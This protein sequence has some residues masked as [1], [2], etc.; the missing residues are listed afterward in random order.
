MMRRYF[1]GPGIGL[2]SCIA[3]LFD[4]HSPCRAAIT[5]NIYNLGTLGG[6]ESRGF[7]INN[8][9]QA[10]GYARTTN[11]PLNAFR[12]SGLPGAGGSMADLGTLGGN[13]AVGNAINASGQV[14]GYSLLSGNTIRHA[15][16]YSGTPG[17]GGMMKDLGTLGGPRSEAYGINDSGQIAGLS[18]LNSSIEHAFRYSGTPGAG[19]VMVDLGTLGGPSSEGHAINNLGQVAGGSYTTAGPY[20]AF[21]YTGT[22]GAGG[23]MEDLGALGGAGSE[24]FGINDIGQVTGYYAPVP[25]SFHAFRYTGT[26]GAGGAM[27]DLTID[28]RNSIGRA[29]NDGGFVVG[30]LAVAA[31]SADFLPVLWLT[32]PAN[33]PVDLDK[34]LD[35][36]NPTQGAYW[37]LVAVNDINNNG[38]ITGS[39]FYDDGPGGLSDGER[40]YILDASGAIPEPAGATLVALVAAG[41]LGPLA[42]GGRA[43]GRANCVSEYKFGA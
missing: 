7:A 30:D 43:G 1:A 37:K 6:D 4:L 32:D 39:G 2:L 11:G 31:G 19:G 28:G 35:A 21:R 24:A 22:P 38:L 3:F 27:V 16:L 33:T 9:G 42:R 41:A 17:A 25:D 5:A 29:I 18:Y 13:S 14:A 40:A 34:W 8:A 26:P 23:M 10:T 15:F 20:H 36:N 12:Y